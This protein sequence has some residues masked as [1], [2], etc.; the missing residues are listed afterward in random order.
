MTYITEESDDAIS[1]RRRLMLS[2]ALG[3]AGAA[4][5]LKAP[6]AKA[7]ALGE[8]NAALAAILAQVKEGIKQAKNLKKEYY[9]EHIKV[10]VDAYKETRD[11]AAAVIETSDTVRKE[12][13]ALETGVGSIVEQTKLSLGHSEQLKLLTDLLTALAPIE[14]KNQI[15]EKEHQKIAGDVTPEQRKSLEGKRRV[16][17][18]VGAS[19]IQ[20]VTSEKK[21]DEIYKRERQGIAK[22]DLSTSSK[23]D[24]VHSANGIKLSS[25]SDKL[26]EIVRL[27]AKNNDL[28][29]GLLQFNATRD[30]D[31][32]YS[33]QTKMSQAAKSKVQ[34]AG[35][36]NW[37]SKADAPPAKGAKT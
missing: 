24:R 4:A 11:T 26:D 1:S 5:I 33:A 29:E 30:V 31:S 32:R 27:M 36:G 18:L 6:E 3:L 15:L 7:S 13:A 37:G 22:V 2:A 10:A 34:A 9:D 35:S 8:E 12:K 20:S 21:L 14:E 25:I 17:A 16:N 23:V 19:R 28:L